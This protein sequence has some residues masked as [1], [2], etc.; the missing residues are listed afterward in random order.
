M[1]KLSLSL[2]LF[3]LSSA[4]QAQTVFLTLPPPGTQTNLSSAEVA[5]IVLDPAESISEVFI[6]TRYPDGS[7]HPPVDE[8][9]VYN[10]GGILGWK[11]DIA[12]DGN[13]TGVFEGRARWMDQGTNFIDIYLP[14]STLG[15]P[16]YTQTIVY[17]PQSVAP[18]AMV[19]GVH[20]V[21]R[22]VDVIDAAGASGRI[23]FLVDLI[24]TTQGTTY[25]VDLEATV[26]LPDGSTVQLPMGG[27]ANPSAS[28]TVAPGDFSFTSVED[29]V[30]M[31]F[32]FPLD[33]APFPQ[34]VQEGEYHMEVQVYEGP[35]LVYEDEDV[36][37]WVVDRAGKAYRDV[38]D[39]A[40]LDVV[41]LQGGN[42]PSSGNSVAVFD[43]NGDALP[44]L[45]FTN[46]SSANTFLPIGE[47]WPY[48]GGT[49]WLMRNEGDGTFSD[50][51][52]AAGVEGNA[53][54]ASYGATWG[55]IDRD[56]HLDLFVANRKRPPYVYHNQ[57][58]GTFIDRA[59]GS[60]GVN[61]PVWW[62]VPRFGDYDADGDLDVYMGAY[63]DQFATTWQLT[64]YANKC[65]RNELSE[66]IDDPLVPGFPK[67]TALDP[68]V[69]LESE[70]LALASFWVD[71]D[72]NGTLDLAV[73][74][75]FGGFTLPNQLFEGDGAGGFSD[76]SATT[77]FDV[78]EFSMGA[79][80]ADLDGDLD[81]DFYSTN[82]GR[83]SLLEN[84]GGTYVQVIEGS[85]AEGDYLTDGPQA[86]GLNLQ[87]DWAVFAFDYD[88]DADVDLY[89]VGSDLETGEHMPIAEIHPDSV[90]RN[91]GGMQFARVTDD[92]GLGNAARGRGAAVIDFDG[93]GD[94]DIVVSNENEGVSLYRNDQTYTNHYLAVRPVTSRSAPGGFNSFLKLTAA[95]KTQVAELMAESTHGGQS[96]NVHWFGLGSA[97]NASLEV[98]WQRGGSTTIFATGADAELVVHETVIEVEGEIDGSVQAGNAPSIVL[99]G[100]PGSF[101]FAAVSQGPG[102]FP[103]PGGGLL[104]IFPL[105]ELSTAAF[106]DGSG[107]AVW[108]FATIPP[109]AAGL[110]AQMQMIE[111][112]LFT[113]KADA[114]S[115]ISSLTILP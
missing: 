26:R 29:P 107:Q 59:Q 79:V 80:A 10:P 67:F 43:Y 2:A 49:N 11:L 113:F 47:N 45:F 30:G 27:G 58:D 86:D 115:G 25:N 100:R 63:M 23:E 83:N 111:L 65:F 110:T 72:R 77:G 60:F 99:H 69:G 34:P 74:N 41:R 6:R 93:D 13:G 15:S 22:T 66:G 21:R 106:L 8:R 3:A 51:S 87:T 103:L 81:L 12:W 88:F 18:T 78:R 102:P 62:E 64:G 20:P 89:V 73:F 44:D 56:G 52:A 91:D 35:A 76:V 85:G 50:Q 104:D 53:T 90:Y 38:T 42:L 55:D 24:N 33:Q 114:K 112:N 57:G 1:R 54:T 39:L 16:D 32:S 36:D 98:E 9:G 92:L 108:P 5:G 14:G 40:G 68:S 46:P 4:A 48:P 82:M 71:H 37:F 31:R 95:G 70:G 75:D 19:A 84:Q 17:Q 109:S 94:Q 7:V 105:F 28:Y 61:T 101:A 96:D 97:T